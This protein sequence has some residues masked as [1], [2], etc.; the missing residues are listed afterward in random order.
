MKTAPAPLFIDPIFCGAADPTLI[1]NRQ[2]RQWWMVYTQR[3]SN[4]PGPG[5][6]NIHGSDLGVASSKDGHDWLYRGTLYGLEFEP[7]RNTFWAPEIL[8]HD[9]LYHMYV[10]YVQGMP[11]DWNRPR[12]IIHYTSDDLWHWTLQGPLALSSPRLI[13]ACVVRLPSGQWR[14]WYKDEDDNCY[15]HCADSPDLYHWQHRGRA[16]T[17]NAHEGA[18]VFRLKD[19]W[20]MVTDFWKG[21]D[22]YRGDDCESWEHMG[23]I[24]DIPGKR[25]GDSALGH[26][27]D[28]LVQGEEAYIFYFT[29]PD[30][31]PQGKPLG[32]TAVQV[33]RL[34]CD[35]Q[36]LTCD[37]DEEFPF[38]LLP[39]EE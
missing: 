19:R 21:L 7:G 10:S 34:R 4:Q 3:R 29:H 12:D 6:A 23:A 32:T 22:V 28:V 36:T 33:A 30:V 27:A 38:V 26:H 37:R 35:G 8:Y 5:F 9:G 25:P 20:W 11:L 31:S 18:N 14:M 1:W 16:I 24:L 39:E 2:E 15:T 17:R 13:D